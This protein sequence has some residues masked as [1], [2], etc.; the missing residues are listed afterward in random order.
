M[1]KH[2]LWLISLLFVVSFSFVSCEE[3][4][5]AVDPYTDWQERNEH[6]LDSIASVALANQGEAVGQWKV[7]HT[8]KYPQQ[9]ITMGDVDEYIYCKVLEV[10]DGET[11]L[12]KDAVKAP[13]SRLAHPAIRWSGSGVRPKLSGL[14]R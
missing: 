14:A 3:T 8:Y 7:I 11:P 5:G 9:G 4:D 1:S 2:I 12:Y 6:Y 13:L 10:G